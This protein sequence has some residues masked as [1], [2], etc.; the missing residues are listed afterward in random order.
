MNLEMTLMKKKDKV[1]E[2][3]RKEKKEEKNTKYKKSIMII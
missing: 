3:G 1:R 2:K